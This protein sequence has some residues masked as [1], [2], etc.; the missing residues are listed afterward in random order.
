MSMKLGATVVDTGTCFR[1]FPQPRFLGAFSEPETIRVNVPPNAMQ[2]GPADDRMFVVDAINKL[3]YSFFFRPPY[4]SDKNP[5][6]HPGPDGHFDHLDPD[7]REF[8]AA[9]M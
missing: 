5:P 8:S 4:R 1:I 6:V 7:S 2:P 9:T 3:P